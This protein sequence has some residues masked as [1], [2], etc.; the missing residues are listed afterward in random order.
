MR[1]EII[2]IIKQIYVDMYNAFC[3]GWHDGYCLPQKK[4]TEEGKIIET[5]SP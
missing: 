1:H 3:A 4:I 2:M 5:F